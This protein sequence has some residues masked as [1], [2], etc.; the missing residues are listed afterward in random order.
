MIRPSAALAFLLLCGCASAP[1][2]Q[3][4]ASAKE[5]DAE[6]LLAVVPPEVMFAQLSE[7]DARS[8]ARPG[9]AE[10][11]HSAFL[12]NADAARLHAIIKS[13]LLRHFTEEELRALAA[14]SRTPEGRACLAKVAPFAAEVVPACAHE[15]AQ[16]FRKTAVEAAR[17][18]MLP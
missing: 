9:Q 15:A 17:G 13:A 7:L 3:T 8:Y 14:F 2:R 4:A 11:A 5:R 10:K 18:L 12:R 16:A 6:E 1:P